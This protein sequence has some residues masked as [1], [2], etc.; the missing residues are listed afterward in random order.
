MASRKGYFYIV[1]LL[2]QNGAN[3]NALDEFQLIVL[4]KHWI[5][6]SNT[7]SFC[8][9]DVPILDNWILDWQW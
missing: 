9:W 3:V 7:P 2:V 4:M 6:P 1:K 8:S 5:I